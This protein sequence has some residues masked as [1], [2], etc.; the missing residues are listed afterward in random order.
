MFPDCGVVESLKLK[1]MS[2]SQKMSVVNI[3]EQGNVFTAIV[4][5]IGQRT[6][7]VAT[8]AGAAVVNEAYV[9][10]MGGGDFVTRASHACRCPGFWL[11]Q[12]KAR[13]QDQVSFN[14]LGGVTLLVLQ[15]AEISKI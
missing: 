3:R 9:L 2:G 15:K 5:E 12:A 4:K 6:Q 11:S 7:W 13:S 10:S 8:L 14:N 1:K